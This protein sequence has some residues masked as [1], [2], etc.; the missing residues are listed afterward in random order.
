MMHNYRRSVHKYTIIRAIERIAAEEHKLIEA[1]IWPQPPEQK[2]CNR[3]EYMRK[4][5]GILYFFAVP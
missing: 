2:I 4:I 5:G 1:G 3:A